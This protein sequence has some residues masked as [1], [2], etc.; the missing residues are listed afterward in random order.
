MELLGEPLTLVK[1]KDYDEYLIYLVHSDVYMTAWT[2]YILKT[3]C[4]LGNMIAHTAGTEQEQIMSSAPWFGDTK[5]FR[6]RE[7]DWTINC[8]KEFGFQIYRKMA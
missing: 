5:F 8:F 3:R 2:V 6:V 1:V 4:S 7:C